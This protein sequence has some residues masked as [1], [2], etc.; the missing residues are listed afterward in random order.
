LGKWHKYA[1]NL[2]NNFKSSRKEFDICSR[3][4]TKMRK[5]AQSESDATLSHFPSAAQFPA[6]KKSL[7]SLKP[8]Q[9][10]N[11]KLRHIPALFH[12]KIKIAHSGDFFLRE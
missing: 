5:G 7:Q 4:T 3:E 9:I 8:L 10:L 12:E 1:A 6:L 2:A 11:K